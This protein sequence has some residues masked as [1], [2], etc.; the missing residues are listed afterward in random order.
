MPTQFHLTRSEVQ[1][2]QADER[3]LDGKALANATGLPPKLI[4]QLTSLGVVEAAAETPEGPV[5]TPAM[6]LRLRRI[7]RL[8]RD[9]SLSWHALGLVAE[10]L[11]RIEG[12][13][14]QL[15]QQGA[16]LP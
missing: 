5:F 12:L 15:R 8:R 6:V 7:V 14:A 1:I 9:L 2:V 4:R 10:L 3:L 11:E 13:E 16:H